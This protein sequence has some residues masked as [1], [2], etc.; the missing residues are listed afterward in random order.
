[1]NADTPAP[2]QAP[3]LLA[4]AEGLVRHRDM[5]ISLRS[6]FITWLLKL[7]LRPMLAR[8]IRGSDES[9][10]RIQLRLMRMRCPNTHGQ[11]LE[12]TVVGALPGHVVGDLRDTGKP[13]ILWLHGG[14]FFLPAAPTA[15]LEMAT[16]LCAQLDAH[17]F[18]PDYRLAPRNRFPAALD[19][20]ERA[21][22]ALLDLGFAPER[23]VLGGDSAGG[24]L[25]LGVLQRI[26]KNGWPMP[27][28]VLPVSPA[29]ELGRIHAP[30]SRPRKMRIDPILP[31][32]ALQR[33]DEMYAGDWDASDPEL[34]PIFA[35]CRGFPPMYLIAS[36]A[37][38]LL[39][40]TVFFARRAKAHGVDVRCDVW[41]VL[42]HAFPLFGTL[43]REV[44]LARADMVAFMRERLGRA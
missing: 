11:S 7:F 31:I 4:P 42:P 33:V 27:A 32:A 17:C 21:Y 34:S 3:L 41:P 20:C 44:R 18:M 15:H 38:V 37:E 14:A 36:D 16:D 30:P 25:A 29:T 40:D 39:D 26:R 10:A 13:V 1:M 2:T 9:I 28:C 5:P 6:R 12:Y 22:R 24:N 19:D 23:I 43:Y 35:D 8:M